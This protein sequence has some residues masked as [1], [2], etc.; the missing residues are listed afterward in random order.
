MFSTCSNCWFNYKEIKWNLEKVS[1]I[2]PF[3]N[4]YIWKG[5]NFPSKIDDWKKFEKNNTTIALNKLHVKEKEIGSAYIS[6][7]NSNS[8]KLIILSMIPNEEKGWHI[9]LQ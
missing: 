4:K 3:I 6:K 8:K 2:T 1:N 9:I 7:I 5:I